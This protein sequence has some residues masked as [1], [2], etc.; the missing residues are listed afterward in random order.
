MQLFSV[1]STMVK[2]TL[3]TNNR[4]LARALES[5]RRELV[6]S[7]QQVRDLTH[8]QQ[9]NALTIA[10]L[11]R[12]VGLKDDEIDKEVNYRLKVRKPSHDIPYY[13]Y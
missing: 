5:V 3:R 12:V 7:Q 13:P 6:Q 4:Q 8:E 9:Q 11:K 10:R 2:Q 1:N